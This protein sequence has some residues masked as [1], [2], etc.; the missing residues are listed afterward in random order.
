MTSG[1][2]KRPPAKG[3]KAGGNPK[4]KNRPDSMLQISV[5]FDPETFNQI[6]TLAQKLNLCFGA[7]VRDLVEW[8]LADME[9]HK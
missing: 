9:Q 3:N 1:M 7:M 6:N 4:Y 2:Y 8:G 5:S